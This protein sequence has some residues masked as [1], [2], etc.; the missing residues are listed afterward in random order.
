MMSGA[1]ASPLA[2]TTTDNPLIVHAFVGTPTGWA[3]PSFDNGIMMQYLQHQASEVLGAPAAGS[4]EM[5]AA[6]QE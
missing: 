1:L 6:E 5:P 4:E 2:C 3:S